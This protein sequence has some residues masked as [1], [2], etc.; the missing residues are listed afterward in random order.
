[1]SNKLT[2][3]QQQLSYIEW[4]CINLKEKEKIY[5]YLQFRCG[6]TSQS[7]YSESLICG[8][9]SKA[10]VR[11]ANA[12]ICSIQ[13]QVKALQKGLPVYKVKT[14]PTVVTNITH[15]KI[16]GAGSSADQ[17]VKSTRP[18]LSIGSQFESPL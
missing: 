4:L 9:I 1:M 16:N 5:I 2:S 11:K 3:F 7:Q 18:D 12:V 13:H 10:S 14:R 17:A 15:Y 6:L 8:G